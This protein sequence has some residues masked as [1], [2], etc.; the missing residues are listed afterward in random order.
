LFKGKVGRV[1]RCPDLRLGSLG[2]IPPADTEKASRNKLLHLMPRLT[3]LFICQRLK[4][5]ACTINPE[6]LK[7]GGDGAMLIT[8]ANQR[9]HPEGEPRALQLLYSKLAGYGAQDNRP[10]HRGR[11][12]VIALRRSGG[13]EGGNENR[14]NSKVVTFSFRKR[15]KGDN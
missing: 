15:G 8:R 10:G 4:G 5:D 1:P 6:G 2:S 9:Y 12:G 14:R 11:K 3:D 7:R 13:H